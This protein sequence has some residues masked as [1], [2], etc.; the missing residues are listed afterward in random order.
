LARAVNLFVE[1]RILQQGVLKLWRAVIGTARLFYRLSERDTVELWR[2]TMG[3]ARV[4]Y[5]GSE[6]DGDTLLI[7]ATAKSA[8]SISDWLQRNHTG[9]LRR[10]LQWVVLGLIAIVTFVAAAGW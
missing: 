1:D 8:L 5:R 7:R 10:N 4:F 9:R 3:T 2:A 6:R